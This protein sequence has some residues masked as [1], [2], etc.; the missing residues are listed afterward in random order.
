MKSLIGRT[1]AVI[2]FSLL[3][4]MVNAK[5]NVNESME[6]DPKGKVEIE[7]VSGSAKII[8]WDKKEVSV[9][10]VLGEYTDEFKFERD[11]SSIIIHVKQKRT[12]RGWNNWG[13]EQGDELVI[14]VPMNSQVD[15][16]STNAQLEMKGIH[17]GAN[18]D[19]VNG[20]IEVDDLLGRIRLESV[21]GNIKARRL[22]GDVAIETVNGNIIGKHSGKKELK[23]STVNGDIEIESDSPEVRAETV[24]GDIELVLQ[25]VTEVIM[26][27]VNG[28]IDVVMNLQKNG[29]VEASS[30]GG[31][32]DLM[33]Q[34]DVAAK[35]D[36]EAHAGGSIKN[37]ITDKEQSKAKYG[38][39]RWLEFSTANPTAT[40]EVST[41]H[42][43]VKVS[44]K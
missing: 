39:R 8:G 33:F 31:S 22:D 21:N 41:V 17:G 30:V 13:S 4:L 27:T 10:G 26:N 2:G 18:V 11:G 15:Y 14:H 28:S 12:S 29:R 9:T 43:R 23:L 16:T 3:A 44:T 25:E 6:A 34:K 42:G 24:N 20:D 35:F 32:V 1:A 36:I 7:H 38:P 5:Q 40:V 19:V 37:K